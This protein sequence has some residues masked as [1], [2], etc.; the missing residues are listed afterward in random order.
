MPQGWSTRSVRI[1]SS[2]LCLLRSRHTG[3][4][5]DDLVTETLHEADGVGVA[6]QWADIDQLDTKAGVA[7][8][9]PQVPVEVSERIDEQTGG[10]PDVRGIASDGVAVAFQ[11]GD[12]VCE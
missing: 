9:F 11:Y 3:E 1:T 8:R 6:R 12:L 2:L 7:L 5:R 4:P 10:Q